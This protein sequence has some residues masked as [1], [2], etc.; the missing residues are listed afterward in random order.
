MKTNLYLNGKKYEIESYK[1][2]DELE[3]LEYLFI[4]ADINE[5]DA[6]SFLDSFLLKNGIKNINELSN[7]EKLILMLKIREISIGDELKIK[8]KCS[9]CNKPSES[10]INL[11]NMI[12]LA[13]TRLKN[14]HGLFN[15]YDAN[16]VKIEDIVDDKIINE[17]DIDEYDNIK[18][19]I[20]KYID[21]YNFTQSCKCEYC[22]KENVF[23]LSGKKLLFSFLSDE[24][25]ESLSRLLHIL[26]YSGRLTR[27]DV[28]NMTPLQRIFE[29][30]LLE[31]TRQEIE[32]KKQEQRG[33]K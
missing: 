22:R 26:V 7:I 4:H 27:E 23:D 32:R 14:V 21:T 18:N 19:N 3:Y 16:N 15:V 8:F 31:E 11:G 29:Y 30:G 10:V 9:H 1:T 25:F 6:N 2:R 5:D 17:L 28:L 12:K 13:E 20:S 33:F 24:N